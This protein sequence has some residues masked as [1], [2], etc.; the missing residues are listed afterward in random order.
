MT[1]ATLL[2][3]LTVKSSI[4]LVVS[5]AIYSLLNRRPAGE[6]HLALLLGA[7]GMLALPVL[8]SLAPLLPTERPTIPAFAPSL[9]FTSGDD[10][11]KP[12]AHDGTEQTNL[13]STEQRPQA[14]VAQPK[15]WPAPGLLAAA[16][17]VVSAILAG[18]MIVGS[19]ITRRYARA[20]ES[21][22]D[23]DL[24]T[25]LEQLRSRM[26]I[27][28][29]V[30]LAFSPTIRTPWV[31]GVFRPVVVLPPDFCSWSRPHRERALIHE[32]SHVRRLDNLSDLLAHLACAAYWINPLVWL[33]A[34]RI[35]A[36][37][38]RASDDEVLLSGASATDY[39]QQLVSLARGSRAFTFPRTAAVAMAT[40][41]SLPS[42]IRRILNCDLRRTSM[43]QRKVLAGSFLAAVFLIPVATLQLQSAVAQS[44]NLGAL[45]V[46]T[47]L[48]L[49]QGP[50]NSEELKQLA[51]AMS[52]SGLY[53][54]L[55]SVFEQYLRTL[56][57]REDTGCRFCTEMLA[58]ADRD[59]DT[60]LF[61]AYESA[62]GRIA[63]EAWDA[64]RDST[65]ILNIAWIRSAA[66]GRMNGDLALYYL[67]FAAQ[68][69][70]SDVQKMQLVRAL[71]NVRQNDAAYEILQ[72]IR[73]DPAS[74]H[75]QSKDTAAFLEFLSREDERL[76]RNGA[77]LIAAGKLSNPAA[78]HMAIGEALRALD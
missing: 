57:Q 33:A 44:G 51:S 24:Q 72:A 9:Q 50:A 37:A 7:I 75:Y 18:V 53:D 55:S 36:E 59:Y 68:L 5:W 77:I 40:R 62:E 64:T 47:Q 25:L 19:L 17:L 67:V 39:A 52:A 2:I 45:D 27:R 46:E 66:G 54:E 21:S 63:D 58:T 26:S 16:Y 28:Q 22:T 29:G 73:A 71:I 1:L 42:R 12:L 3:D 61:R 10:E 4:I 60:D 15:N 74:V 69:G 43:N 11:L 8:A 32:L 30:A 20:L 78:Q 6:R 31:V 76:A 14:A 41:S 23:T 38:E 13:N 34:R 70:I 65:H 48:I 49:Q 35:R 56:D